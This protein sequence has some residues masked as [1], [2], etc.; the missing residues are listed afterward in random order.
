[1]LKNYFVTAFRSA[2]RQK[3]YALI[4][5]AGLSIG[6][7]CSFFILLWVTDEMSYDRFHDDGAQIHQAW[8][9][10]NTGGQVYTLNSLPTGIADTLAAEY[11]EVEDAVTTRLDTQFVVTLGDRSFHETGG[12]A[13]PTFFQMF[14]FPFIEGDATS[15]LQDVS[16]IVITE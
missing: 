5:V 15:A 10:M 2:L 16:S 11:P 9:H 6:L 14:T 3:V 12:H 7:A 1:M 4:N 8:R 13:S